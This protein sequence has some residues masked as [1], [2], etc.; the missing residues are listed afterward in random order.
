MLQDKIDKMLKCWDSHYGSL[1]FKE[2]LF[3]IH[4]GSLEKYVVQELARTLGVESKSFAFATQRIPAINLLKK[5][6]SKLSQIY[7]APPTR[8]IVDGSTSDQDQLQFYI[9]AFSLDSQMDV[10]NE[11]Y[12]LTKICFVMPYYNSVSD[13]LSLRVLLPHQFLP[14]GDDVNERTKITE[15][16]TY[17]GKNAQN[18]KMFY[19]YSDEEF[20]SFDEDGKL[21]PTESEGVN[22][23]GAI[24]GV[25]IRKSRNLLYPKDDTDMKSMTILIPTMLADLNLASMFSCFSIMYMIDVAE[26]DRKYAP[27]AVWHLKSD[28][29]S[30]KK[31]TIGTIKPEADIEKTI[32]LIVTEFTMWL[33]SKGIK[34]GSIGTLTV[35]NAASGISK[36]IDEMDTMEDRQKQVLI[37]GKAEQADL[38][39]LIMHKMHPVWVAQGMKTNKLFTPTAKV[40]VDFPQQEALKSR[41]ERVAD[42]KMEVD[43]GFMS[44]KTAIEKLNHGLPEEEIQKIIEE[45]DEESTVT[46]MTDATVI[47]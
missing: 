4:E 47:E 31:P 1:E 19:A 12:N 42:L 9:D 18:R 37:F 30:D 33:N 39:P 6:V 35:D 14:F 26:E 45:I 10:A 44:R 11:F 27:N 32:S 34:P 13:K 7:N 16:L 41:G 20:I 3:N 17:Q 2:D 43:A 22:I 36:M 46:V 5:I 38:W 24:P 21:Y 23:F 15:L 40:K 25:Y 29:D 8:S 28:N